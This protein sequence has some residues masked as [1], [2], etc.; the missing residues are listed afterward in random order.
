MFTSLR[1]RLP[2]SFYFMEEKMKLQGILIAVQNMERSLKFYREIFNQDVIMDFGA[3]KTLRCGLSLQSDFDKLAEFDASLMK[4]HTHNMELYF[5]TDDFDAFTSL[6][7][8]HPEVEKLHEAKTF[9]WRQRGIRIYDPDGHIVE[10]SESMESV[11]FKLFEEGKTIE[12]TVKITQHPQNIVEQWYKRFLGEE[13]E[14][15]SVCGSN[16][17]KC[18]YYKKMC[19]G[20][21]KSYGKVFHS[22][23]GCAIYSCVQSKNLH[24]CG[25]CS[26][27]PCKIWKETRDPSYSDEQFEKSIAERI[28]TLKTKCISKD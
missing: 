8:E 18:P 2:Y 23:Q 16:C 15:I 10:V 14:N 20:C 28:K 13:D 3:N 19:S 22:P 24:D 11:G 26:S 9:P 21:N 7:N 5:E 6:L 17:A 4:F 12:E 27:L 1:C 25:K